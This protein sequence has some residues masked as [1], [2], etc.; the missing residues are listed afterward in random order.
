MNKIITVNNNKYNLS[1]SYILGFFEGDGSCIIQLKSNSS[2]KTGKQVV[3]IFEFHQ[4]SIDIDFLK[5]ISIYLG[6]GKVEIGKK[7]QTK[8]NK[9]IIVYRLR[10]SS[11][12][13]VLS[14]LLPILEDNFNNIILKKR[15]NTLNLFIKACYIVKNKKHT[16]VEGLNEIKKL[17][18]QFT[19][20]LDLDEKNKLKSNLSILNHPNKNE[21]IRGFTD[22]EGSFSFTIYNVNDKYRINFNFNIVQ[23]NLELPFLK[24]LIVLF[25]CGHV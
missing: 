17:L 1:L 25:G 3:L 13:E 20:K 24:D 22:A 5:A 10:I 14:I 12:S 8:D 21:W 23:E 7:S 2:H 6:C 4:H 15:W 18:S 19:S 11:Q 16:T 9:E